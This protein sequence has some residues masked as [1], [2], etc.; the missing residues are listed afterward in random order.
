MPPEP[1]EGSQLRRSFAR[2]MRELSHTNPKYPKR[3]L[4]W[5]VEL[6]QNTC[7]HNGKESKKS[8]SLFSGA[9]SKQLF[10][11]LKNS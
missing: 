5:E 7:K 9:L 6:T 4:D 8:R 11:T 2:A 3:S 1:P 10:Y